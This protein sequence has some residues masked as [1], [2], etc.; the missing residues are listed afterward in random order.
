MREKEHEA[1]WVGKEV[2]RIW[3]EQGKGKSMIKMY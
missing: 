1:G 2:G 3:K